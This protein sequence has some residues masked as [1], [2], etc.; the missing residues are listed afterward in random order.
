MF[1]MK[2]IGDKKALFLTGQGYFLLLLTINGVL[3]LKKYRM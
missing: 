3:D 2:T 1:K